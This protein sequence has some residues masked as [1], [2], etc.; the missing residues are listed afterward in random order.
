M[1][2]TILYER[3]NTPRCAFPSEQLQ[4]TN[5]KSYYKFYQLKLRQLLKENSSRQEHDG[6]S[7]K[8]ML[9][10]D[11]RYSQEYMNHLRDKMKI[12]S[13]NEDIGRRAKSVVAVTNLRAK[14]LVTITITSTEVSTTN[15][16]IQTES[17]PKSILKTGQRIIS[18]PANR[19]RNL[20][21][22]TPRKTREIELDATNDHLSKS[23]AYSYTQVSSSS[24][25]HIDKTNRYARQSILNTIILHLHS[26]TP[27]NI[28][29]W[30]LYREF[31]EKFSASISPT[32]YRDFERI[33]L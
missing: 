14:E 21:K 7:S 28:S 1:T 3:I 16:I 24:Q 10:N 27:S 20:R 15:T 12:Q 17:R 22:K 6:K 11:K 32:V 18:A 31:N 30:N 8:Q 25:H 26:S 13:Q 33:I 5:G 2:A 4:L 9:F 23:N 19:Q 29:K